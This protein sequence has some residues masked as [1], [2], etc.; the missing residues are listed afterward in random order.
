M[1]GLMRKCLKPVG[2]IT[3][4]HTTE[5]VPYTSAKGCITANKKAEL[6]PMHKNKGW[7][8]SATCQELPAPFPTEKKAVPPWTDDTVF[9]KCLEMQGLPL[10]TSQTSPLHQEAAN[11][12][13]YGLWLSLKCTLTHTI[14]HFV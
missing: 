9:G 14:S 10:N 5:D 12:W 3:V 8:S 1:L 7:A 2:C 6:S 11:S 4:C 13:T